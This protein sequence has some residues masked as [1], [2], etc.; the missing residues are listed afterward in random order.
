MFTKHTPSFGGYL[1]Q[2][3][4]LLWMQWSAWLEASMIIVWSMWVGRNYLDFDPTMLPEGAWNEFGTAIQPHIIWTWINTCGLC[5]LWNGALNG[6]YPAFVDL[7]GAQLHPLVIASSLLWGLTL[8]AKVTFVASLAMAGLGQWWLARVLHLGFIARIWSAALVVTGGHLLG[9]MEHGVLAVVVSTAACSLV[10]PPALELALYARR[11]SAI[12]LGIVLALAIVSGQGYLQIGV[13][14]GFGPALLVLVLNRDWTIRPI[15]KEFLLAGLLGLLLSAIFLVPLAHF[16]PN[17]RK[18]VDPTFE[19]AQ[20][21]KW[22][23]LN[24]V[25][26]DPQFYIDN[27]VLHKQPYPY[28]YVNYITWL[29]VLLA[30]VAIRLVPPRNV[31]VVLFFI[32]GLIGVYLVS[33][34]ASL[35]L[36]AIVFPNFIASIRNPSL[37]AGLA[38][39]LV[40]GLAAYGLDLFL[41]TGWSALYLPPNEAATRSRYRPLGVG[42]VLVL[43][44]LGW[45]L[46][47]AYNFNHR[48]I[49]TVPQDPR[50]P[51]VVRA[52]KTDTT[53]WVEQVY[54]I[55][56]WTP[57]ALEAG[58][59]LTNAWRPWHWADRD[60]PSPTIQASLQEEA[61][62]NS[63][64]RETIDGVH[65]VDFEDNHY[66]YVKLN[67]Q[68]VPCEAQALGGN[69]EIRCTTLEPGQLVV[70]ENNLTGWKAYRNGEAIAL[71]DGRWLT[72]E[73]LPGQHTYSF[74][75]RP[76][77][78]GLGAGLTL[79]GMVLSAWLWF[80][81]SHLKSFDLAEWD[82]EASSADNDDGAT[83]DRLD[84]MK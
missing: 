56:S 58:L 41:K 57:A 27:A 35:Q 18:D 70:Q 77:D 37:I 52:L 19:S 59:K 22:A 71:Q 20:P 76:L 66:A 17:F 65:I 49:K 54:G 44:L 30:V 55:H 29:P 38:V 21:L 16:W 46:N 81:P 13:L 84:D 42:S 5:V 79:V 36:L 26:N 43:M 78:V 23:V 33:S 60:P 14:L 31:R 45:S 6:G 32:V 24:L 80:H 69:I 9:R 82:R 75:Y 28:L 25:I 1:V 83:D 47:S 63:G 64:L 39:P 10:L 51:R 50:I 12:L 8:G 3:R 48:W 62:L 53:T 68:L 67:T 4:S 40:V 7:H 74:R 34:A 61:K 72:V 11:R 2:L 73:A 15:W